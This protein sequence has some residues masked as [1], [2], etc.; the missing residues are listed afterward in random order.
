MAGIEN[1]NFGAGHVAPVG[2]GFF[3][4]E[5]RVKATPQYEERRLVAAQP[6]CHA[7]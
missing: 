5:R 1:V 7:G 2:F 3:D 6:A 4:L